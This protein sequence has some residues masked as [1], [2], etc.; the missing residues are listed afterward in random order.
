LP[1][2]EKACRILPASN[3]KKREKV[4][5]SGVTSTGTRSIVRSPIL[6]T[7]LNRLNQGTAKYPNNALPV[8]LHAPE[9]G[10][11]IR[12]SWQLSSSFYKF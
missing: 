9:P 2:G 8:N 1:N 12:A 7:E 3:L 6:L 4:A 5:F 10:I 11:G